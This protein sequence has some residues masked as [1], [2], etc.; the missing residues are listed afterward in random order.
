MALDRLIALHAPLGATQGLLAAL[1]SHPAAGAA[2]RKIEAQVA[3]GKL[4]PTAAAA[5]LLEAFRGKGG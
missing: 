1:K 5:R 3:A 2:V 4:S